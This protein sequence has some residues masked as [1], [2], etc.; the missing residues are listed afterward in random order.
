VAGRATGTS[1]IVGIAL[2]TTAVPNS[3]LTVRNPTGNP[4]ALTIT[5]TA[6]GNAAVSAHLV[7]T[8]LA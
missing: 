3:V 4:A 1:Q 7:I 6:G 2:V 8:R 5:T